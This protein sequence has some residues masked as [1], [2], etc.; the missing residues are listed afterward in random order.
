[1]ANEFAFLLYILVLLEPSWSGNHFLTT[2]GL[3]TEKSLKDLK[4]AAAERSFRDLKRKGGEVCAVLRH[5][6]N[7]SRLERRKRQKQKEKEKSKAPRRQVIVT[8]FMIL[9]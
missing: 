5:E 3:A 1:L 2:Q 7:K 4:G 6:K 9:Y 8:C